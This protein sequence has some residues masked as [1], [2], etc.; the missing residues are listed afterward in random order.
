MAGEF[1]KLSDQIKRGMLKG[2]VSAANKALADTQAYM[3]KDLADKTGLKTKPIR[4]RLNLIKATVKNPGGSISFVFSKKLNLIEFSAKAGTMVR[5]NKLGPLRKK[6]KQRV[7][8]TVSVSIG[9]FTNV[10]V[11][12]GFIRRMKSGAVIVVG[13]A[14]SVGD[15]G[16]YTNTKGSRALVGIK[17]D[18]VR[19]VAT[20]SVA[21]Y[22]QATKDTFDRIKDSEVDFAIAQATSG[23][24]ISDD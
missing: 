1:K 20:S 11:P 19:D 7:Y 16:T 6:A 5:P 13:R 22:R 15:D 23:A 18:I 12:G 10:L 2:A 14:N 21:G 4:D 8:D 9:G 3:I 24:T 17:T